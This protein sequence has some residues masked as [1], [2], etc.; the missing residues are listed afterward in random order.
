MKSRQAEQTMRAQHA[1]PRRLAVEELAFVWEL[2]QEWERALGL[3]MVT[4]VAVPRLLRSGRWRT[5][6]RGRR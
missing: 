2:G 4:L 5:A 1:R 3:A 6:P